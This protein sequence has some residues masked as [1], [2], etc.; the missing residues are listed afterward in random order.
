MKKLTICAK[1][2]IVLMIIELRLAPMYSSLLW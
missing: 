2:V 1:N